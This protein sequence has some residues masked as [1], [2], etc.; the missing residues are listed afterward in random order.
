MLLRG[1]GVED[2][3]DVDLDGPGDRVLTAEHVELPGGES[4]MGPDHDETTS[5]RWGR[6]G[7]DILRGERCP[8]GLTDPSP[9]E[10][11]SDPVEEHLS[12]RLC[13]RDAQRESPKVVLGDG[14]GHDRSR[15]RCI[16]KGEGDRHGPPA[17]QREVEHHNV[18]CAVS[19]AG[20]LLDVVAEVGAAVSEGCVPG[21]L[22][23]GDRRQPVVAAHVVNPADRDPAR[24]GKRRNDD[25]AVDQLAGH[26]TER[27]CDGV[28][29]EGEVPTEGGV[30]TAHEGH[31][32]A[33][34]A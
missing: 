16:R 8:H 12:R 13:R 33:A 14:I 22:G 18:G 10:R 23:V 17:D 9:H 27:L 2:P 6:L 19:T 29:L 4:D 31:G 5:S 11:R 25:D 1:G 28:R 32:H 15:V 26:L 34:L 30:A 3:V 7:E 20:L 24:V 21:E